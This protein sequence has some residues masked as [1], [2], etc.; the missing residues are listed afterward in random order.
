MDAA[1]EIELINGDPSLLRVRANNGLF[2]GYSETYIN[3][4]W[5]LEFAKKLEGF[6]RNPNAKVAFES[7]PGEG[8]NSSVYLCALCSDNI[9]HSYLSIVLRNDRW[10]KDADAVQMKLKVEPASIDVF[11]KAVLSLEGRRDGAAKLSGVSVN[12]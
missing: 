12:A 8:V 7:E 5:L 2:S 3:K 6:P 4:K 9:G 10:D 11:S 1:L